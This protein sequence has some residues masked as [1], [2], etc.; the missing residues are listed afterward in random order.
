MPGLMWR[1]ERPSTSDRLDLFF[2]VREHLVDLLDVAVGQLLH[3]VG[4]VAMLVLRD[5]VILLGLLQSFH[6]VATDVADR[7][8]ALLGVFVGKLGELDA[9]LARELGNRD[10]DELTV[11]R[12]IEAEPRF[13]DG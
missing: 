9:P 6:A 12:R 13:T 11:G 2:L 7:N 8:T 3:L 10:A 5:L 1:A 4:L